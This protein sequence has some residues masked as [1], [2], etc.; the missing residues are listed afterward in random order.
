MTPLRSLSSRVLVA[1]VLAVATSAAVAPALDAPQ[2]APAN[3]TAETASLVDPSAG[4]G[5]SSNPSPRV[6]PDTLR[7]VVTNP[8]GHATKLLVAFFT[9]AW[10][11]ARSISL[12]MTQ[13]RLANL[14]GRSS[15][16]GLAHAARARVY[17]FEAATTA[18]GT[19]AL[20]WG[21]EVVSA[22]ALQGGIGLSDITP[23]WATANAVG[24][25]L[26]ACTQ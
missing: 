20:A 24:G 23:G 22:V 26:D 1:V 6:R 18:A 21:P 3:V 9:G 14:A 4:G 25:M 12:D 7:A 2:P 15:A 13:A 11:V 17:A 16:R 19:A 5:T 10:A 8:R